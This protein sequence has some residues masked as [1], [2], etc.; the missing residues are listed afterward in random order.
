MWWIYIYSCNKIYQQKL[1]YKLIFV[2]LNVSMKQVLVL[3]VFVQFVN[4]FIDWKSAFLQF[5]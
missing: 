4:P 5:G 3:F 1:K 2:I